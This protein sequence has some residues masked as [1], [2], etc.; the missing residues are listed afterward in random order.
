MSRVDGLWID[1]SGLYNPCAFVF[2]GRFWINLFAH[3]SV[4]H[5]L[6]PLHYANLDQF[7]LAWSH[8]RIQNS[9]IM[10]NYA[11]VESHSS[12]TLCCIPTIGTHLG[13]ECHK[14][15]EFMC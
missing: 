4:L 15:D 14:I 5:N 11:N 6:H 13:S 9:V 3:W 10:L 2:A 7:T 8:A 1:C 12:Q